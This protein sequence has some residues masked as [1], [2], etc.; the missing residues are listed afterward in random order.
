MVNWQF[1]KERIDQT[2]TNAKKR[3]A[4]I[5]N[6]K[7]KYT[8]GSNKNAGGTVADVVEAQS[9]DLG[10]GVTHKGMANWW[11]KSEKSFRKLKARKISSIM[12]DK[13]DWQG[14]SERARGNNEDVSPAFQK[15]MDDTRNYLV[16]RDNDIIRRH[17]KGHSH[18]KIAKDTGVH[19]GI[20]KAVAN[21][22]AE[23]PKYDTDPKTGVRSTSIPKH[24][25]AEYG[26]HVMKAGA[27]AG[28]YLR[29]TEGQYRDKLNGIKRDQNGKITHRNGKSVSEETVNEISQ[30]KGGKWGKSLGTSSGNQ[31]PAGI[32]PLSPQTSDRPKDTFDVN[33]GIEQA[34]A[35]IKARGGLKRE[36]TQLE[37]TGIK[38]IAHKL[39]GKTIA[40]HRAKQLGKQVAKQDDQARYYSQLAKGTSAGTSKQDY[41]QR[42]EYK[43]FVK[44]AEQQRGTSSRARGRYQNIATQS[45]PISFAKNKEDQKNKIANNR[46][47]NKY[48]RS[49]ETQLDELSRQKLGQY[50]KRASKN[51]E[52]HTTQHV[53]RVSVPDRSHIRKVSRRQEGIAKAVGRLTKEETVN[54]NEETFRLNLIKHILKEATHSRGG[55]K[56]RVGQENEGDNHPI[57]IAR[58]SINLGFPVALTHHNKEKTHVTPQ[59]GHHILSHYDNLKKPHE[60]EEMIHHLWK[61]SAH[62]QGYLGGN[63]LPTS[64]KAWSP[65]DPVPE[66]S[67]KHLK[68]HGLP[69]K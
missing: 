22:A 41:K 49:E 64:E 33:K 46:R 55:G 51:I 5:D 32:K 57:N 13:R 8:D 16:K 63:K 23:W 48:I 19:F 12:K 9:K 20:V 18:E 30:F 60:K 31:K 56:K 68:A 27:A 62:L 7:A 67:K 11:K 26:R 40:K 38:R 10:N 28:R 44:D 21:E 42:H 53:T 45:W 50:V 37:S 59:M 6:D 35:R 65:G 47:H 34:K 3:K 36:E 14:N 43:K 15:Q 25:Q 54:H 52:T 58:K 17:K 2:Y 39:F 1:I 24:K 29:S 69:S 61:S 4:A 66:R